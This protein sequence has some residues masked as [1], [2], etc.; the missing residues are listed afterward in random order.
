MQPHDGV[1]AI[2]GVIDFRAGMVASVFCVVNRHSALF[3]RCLDVARIAK[4]CGD[5]T[6]THA[7]NRKEF[8]A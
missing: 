3:A 7:K 6:C 5:S 1:S 8:S 2:R 4:H